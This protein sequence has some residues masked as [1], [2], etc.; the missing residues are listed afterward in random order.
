MDLLGKNKYTE[1]PLDFMYSFLLTSQPPI[2][3]STSRPRIGMNASKDEMES[4][5]NEID[6]SGTGEIYFADFVRV[7]SKKVDA[8]Y[9]PEQV[10]SAFK[11]FA[12]PHAPHGMISVEALEEA[13]S[14]YEGKLP[15][16]MATELVSKVCIRVQYK[17][18]C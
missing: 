12:G 15:K 9:S 4:M 5:M 16:E 14:S 10:I 18:L 8:Q 13:L 6:T 2:F 1:L 3:T 11:K 7:M 17:F